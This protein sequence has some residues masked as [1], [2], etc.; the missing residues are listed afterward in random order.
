MI[1]SK[2]VII[3]EEKCIM[4]TYCQAMFPPASNSGGTAGWGFI[5]V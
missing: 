2:V 1:C 3:L 4:L 5:I